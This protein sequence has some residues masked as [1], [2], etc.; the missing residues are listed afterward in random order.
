MRR[1]VSYGPALVVLL[2]ILA[3]LTGAPALVRR[4]E[5]EQTRARVLLAR[6]SLDEGD[7]I[8]ERVNRAN[9]NV[10]DTVRP[11]V[12]H[13]DVSSSM[14]PG[15]ARSAGTGWV[16]DDKGHIVTNAH[17]LFGVRSIR[18]NFS[19]GRVTRASVVGQPDPYTDIAVIKVDDAAGV[20]PAR[21]AT[22]DQPRQGD[23]VFVFGSPFGFKFSMS[24]GIVSGLGRDPQ[25][26]MDFGGFTNF[27]QTD[28]AVNPGNSGG[29][30][31]DI[32]GRVI[33][34]NVAIATGRNSQGSSDDEG[35]SAGISFAIPLATIESVAEQ[36]IESGSVARGFM[37][38]TWNR[39]A[40]GYDD[41]LRTVGVRIG[42]V[43]SGGPADA[44][45]LE[46]GDFITE[47]GGQLVSGD[48]VL[49]SVITSYRP[50]REV[51]IKAW[52]DGTARDFNVVLGEYPRQLLNIPAARNALF[53]Y[54]IMLD[55]ARPIV[56]EV[57]ADSTASAA[58]LRVGTRFVKIGEQAITSTEQLCLSLADQGFLVGHAV[59]AT[60]KDQDEDGNER[61]RV[62]TLRPSR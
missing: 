14:G 39:G 19:D 41:R 61:E 51:V 58:S 37:G 34:M 60:I 36:I 54:G 33:G 27:I 31:V 50:G 55:A 3:M 16:Y 42:D 4:M 38:I 32:H 59:R 47:I 48:G 56:E 22:G 29:P 12:V 57:L 25:T 53:R 15:R 46:S 18:V 44:A 35:Q 23:R 45:G 10:A 43:T 26:A 49:E 5:T 62:I 8:L 1:F 2:T 11:S 28:A 9:R 40:V 7:D 6:Q 17:V 24:Q 52:R 30:L 13:L 20:I 21:R